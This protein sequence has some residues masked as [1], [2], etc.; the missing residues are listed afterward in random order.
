MAEHLSFGCSEGLHSDVD[1]VVD[2]RVL[3]NNDDAAF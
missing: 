3:S 2:S 1:K